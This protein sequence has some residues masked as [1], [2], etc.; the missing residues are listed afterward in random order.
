MQKEELRKIFNQPYNRESWIRTL[1]ATFKN[2]SIF[3]TPKQFTAPN[4][5]IDSFAQLGSIRLNDGKSLALFEVILSDNVN[6]VKNKVELRKLVDKYIDME[7]AHGVLSIYEQGGEDYRFTFAAKSTEF[8]DE[9]GGFINKETDRKRYTYVLGKNESCKTAADQFYNLAQNKENTT[10]KE[11]QDAFNVDKLSK[12]FFTDYKTHYEKL[13]NFLVDSANGFKTSIFKDDEKHIRDFVKILLGRLVFI[14]FI[15][16]K[17]WMGVDKNRQDWKNGQVNFLHRAFK[18]F[19]HK[20]KFYSQFLYPLFFEALNL[21]GRPNGVFEL[22]QSKVPYLNGGLFENEEPNTRNVDFPKVY[23]EALFEFFDQYNFTID[24]NDPEEREVGIDPEMLGHIFE[25]LLEDNKSKGTFYTPKEIVH[26]MCQE[27]LKEYLKTYLEQNNH[28]PS[29]LEEA[30]SLEDN[31]HLFVAKKQGAGIIEFE[32]PLA[33]ALKYVKICDP[34]IGSGAF[35]MGLLNE[36]FQCVYVLY[37]PGNDAVKEVWGMEEWQPNVVKLNIIQNSIYGVDIEKGAVDIA[38]L[39]FWLSLIVDEPEPKALP[40]LDYKIVVGNSLVSKFDDEVLDINWDES[41]RKGSA[42]KF[43]EKLH[44]SL[45]QVSR[46]QKEFFQSDNKEQ[47]KNEIRNL[48]IDAIF[49]QISLNK[50]IYAHRNPS[51]LDT[52]FGLK[53]KEIQKNSEITLTL[54]GFDT[55]LEK[56]R[57][58]KGNSEEAFNF[59]DW[60]LDFP[61]VMNEQI[62]E[63]VGFDIIIAN[64]PYVGVKG[65][66]KIFDEIKQSNLAKFSKGRSELFYF[67]IHQAI[68]LGK[69]NCINTFITTNYFITASDAIVLRKSLKEE[70]TILKLINFNEI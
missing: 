25:N 9:S 30:K 15:Q 29:N 54:I 2:V 6:G 4:E 10:I 52:G 27:S 28:W 70:T 58:L 38:R 31:L 26:Y 41:N 12:Q 66:H 60:K 5:K 53:Q 40:N 33:K 14:Q 1:E 20:D 11:V 62:T 65:N 8:D 23:F 32:E 7:Q 37:G 68:C 35:P 17:G 61:E 16:K 24:E 67:F 19:E 48:K 47:L 34:A 36:I 18:E 3:K 21:A 59:F 46:K 56:L 69:K 63:K 44:E 55:I 45:I 51:K 64:P 22:T 42:S 13:A 39:R 50:E 43:F 57:S 49:N